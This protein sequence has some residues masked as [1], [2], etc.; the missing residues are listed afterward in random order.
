MC[1]TMFLKRYMSSPVYNFC[2]HLRVKDIM[3]FKPSPSVYTL[4]ISLLYI[5]EEI[6]CSVC[7]RSDLQPCCSWC[8][9][10]GLHD[11]LSGGAISHCKHPDTA[12][13]SSANS[14][15]LDKRG[16]S[17]NPKIMTPFERYFYG[18]EECVWQANGESLGTK[19]AL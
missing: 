6:E 8:C 4:L 2:N 14:N 7:C 11:G 16:W 17:V 13:W 19:L 12:P 18:C 9:T 5:R 3:S 10:G 15:W 1:L